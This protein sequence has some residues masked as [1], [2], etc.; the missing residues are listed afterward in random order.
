MFSS[1]AEVVVW[2]LGKVSLSLDT[3]TLLLW[4]C[5]YTRTY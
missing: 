1:V 4:S 2:D 5:V 3:I